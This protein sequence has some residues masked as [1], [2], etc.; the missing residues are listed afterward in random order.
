[1]NTFLILS[2]E[3]LPTLENFKNHGVVIRAISAKEAFSNYCVIFREVYEGY[4]LNIETLDVL[5]VDRSYL[6]FKETYRHRLE[7]LTKPVEKLKMHKYKIIPN[8][9]KHPDSITYDFMMNYFTVESDSPIN[10]FRKYY[11]RNGFAVSLD[12]FGY[13]FDT[14]SLDLYYVS[15]S[16]DEQIGYSSFAK[17]LEKPKMKTYRLIPNQKNLNPSYEEMMASEYLIEAHSPKNALERHRNLN[18]KVDCGMA[19]DIG[20]LDLYRVLYSSSFINGDSYSDCFVKKLEKPK[21]ANNLSFKT[22]AEA[23]LKRI[24]L[25]KNSKGLPA[26]SK[27]DG[28]D[29]SHAEWLQAVIGELGEYANIMKKVQRGDLTMEEA[30]PSIKK[31]IADVQTYFSI[32]ALRLGIDLGQVTQD[33]FNEVSDK[34]KCD[35]YIQNDKVVSNYEVK[36]KKELRDELIRI[37]EKAKKNHLRAKTYHKPMSFDSNQLTTMLVGAVAGY[38]MS[39]AYYYIVNSENAYSFYKPQMKIQLQDLGNGK[40]YSKTK[41][42]E[43]RTFSIPSAPLLKEM[44]SEIVKGTLTKILLNGKEYETNCVV[45][46]GD[47]IQFSDERNILYSLRITE[48]IVS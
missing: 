17:K 21:P 7:K 3:T 19:L 41:E 20:T 25:F 38:L 35:V 6:G 10:A 2:T 11:E 15:W 45:K 24:P 30:M 46:V 40:V 22:L 23:N 31:E 34:V 1:M 13:V 43:K 16:V 42:C 18:P 47:L 4:A 37:K 26:H 5:N 32:L 44:G 39:P 29:W 36:S 27:P 33:K 48:L 28:S 12:L 14:E 8:Q 9:N